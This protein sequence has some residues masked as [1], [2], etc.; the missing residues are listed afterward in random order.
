MRIRSLLFCLL[1]TAISLHAQGTSTTVGTGII[2]S[3]NTLP[4]TCAP[5]TVSDPGSQALFY[6]TTATIDLYR[7][8]A[9]NTY[10]QV[11]SASGGPPTGAAGGDLSGTYPN[12]SVA[13]CTSCVLTTPALGTPSSATLTNATGLPINGVV[14]A[15]GAIATIANGNNP[16]TVNC[17]LT[18]GTTCLTTGETTAASTAGAVEHQI[19]TLTTSTA[20]PVQITQGANGPAAANAPAVL[21]IAAAA[22][23]GLASASINGLTGAPIGLAT[24]AG[25][26]GGATTG[27]GGTGGSYTLTTGAGG[28]AGGTTTNTGGAGG[29]ENI[30]LGAGTAG[31]ATGAGGAAGVV[32]YTGGAG[33]AGGA[34]SG[35]GGA[36]SDFLVTTGT[37]GA[38][39]VGSTTGRGGNA[40]FT[41]GSA[42]GTGTAGL[43]GQFKIAG[44]TVGA[45]NTTPFFNMTGTWNTT[46]VVDAAFFMNITNT[47]SGAA[48]KM[49]DI[50]L[51]GASYFTVDK[52]GLVAAP[53]GSL[54]AI[55]YLTNSNCSG[56]GTA[57][58]PSVVTCGSAAAGSFSCATNASG[59]TCQVNTTS[60][61]ANSQIFIQEDDSLG[62]KLSVTCN[63][64]NLSPTNA[65]VAARSGGASFTISLGTVSV[66]PECFSYF[67]VN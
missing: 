48:S 36:G 42:G 49:V 47:L 35:T 45:A 50:Q 43:P 2:P 39:T 3:G 16:L 40:T 28:A 54:K 56:V 23:G 38:A 5:S 64:A 60:V 65:P 63:T 33:G 12:P 18:S 10:T 20:I 19:T 8:T 6:K 13:T 21:N 7:C 44:G 34:T 57:A 41:L 59:G 52:S 62:T 67:I 14:S 31:A 17:A 46:G 9:I 11:G 66:N 58:N 24:G 29:G 4:T 55:S 37:G 25:S 32:T 53:Q 15:T 51:G 27:N 26:A 30:N 22:A 1:A 61:T